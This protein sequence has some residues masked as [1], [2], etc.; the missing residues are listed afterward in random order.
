M[1]KEMIEKKIDELDTRAF[2]I[3]MADFLSN[4]D[5]DELYEIRRERQ[6]LQAMLNNINE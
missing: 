1:T 6:E 5:W 3:K 2:L 4:S